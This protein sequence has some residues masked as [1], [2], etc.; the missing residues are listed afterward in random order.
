VI[1]EA[2]W[3]GCPCHPRRNDHDLVGVRITWDETELGIAVKKAGG[4]RRTRQKLRE[5][6]WDALRALGIG[7]RVVTG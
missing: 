4:I 1:D 3:R 7:H 2:P 6:S 5:L